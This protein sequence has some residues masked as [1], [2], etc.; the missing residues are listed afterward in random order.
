MT[1]VLL[2]SNDPIFKSKSVEAITRAGFKVTDVSDAFDGLLLVDRDG[3]STIV[4]DEELADI[5][6]YRAFEKTRQY[7]KVPL[8]LLGSESSEDV[9]SRVNKQ[10]FDV[11]LKKPVTPVE[12]VAQI[13]AAVKGP[14]PGEGTMPA[15]LGEAAKVKPVKQEVEQM[16]PNSPVIEL[17]PP[18]K[19]PQIQATS[20]EIGHE[21]ALLS[22]T[23]SI[24]VMITDLECQVLKIKTAISK[25][26]ELRNMI[27]DTKAFI[28]QQQKDLNFVENRL[29]EINDQL[30]SILGDSDI[31]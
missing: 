16:T 22:Q 31:P 7:S 30:K 24:E 15:P 5:D 3:F 8:I 19:E 2:M 26:D 20:E 14:F 17:P 13:K 18:A 23:D 12:L 21:T 10:E 11:Y 29:Q 9:W 1:Q 28:R 4:I 25:I 6:G 27:D